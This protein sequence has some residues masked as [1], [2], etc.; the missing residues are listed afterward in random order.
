MIDEL[1]TAQ[2]FWNKKLYM[3][4]KSF[5]KSNQIKVYFVLVVLVFV[6]NQFV[7]NKIWW[8]TDGSGLSH[9]HS[10]LPLVLWPSPC[11]SDYQISGRW[12]VLDIFWMKTILVEYHLNN[13]FQTGREQ[14]W[15]IFT[16]H[17]TFLP[18]HWST[19]ATSLL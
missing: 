14:Q 16:S 15:L 19:S 11:T 2:Q 10:F 13:L 12:K 7:C 1:I 4:R 5:I 9:H 3:K 8:Q 18:S 17:L 6:L